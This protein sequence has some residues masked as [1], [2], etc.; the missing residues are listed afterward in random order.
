MQTG[1]Y[2]LLLESVDFQ[3]CGRVV[4]RVSDL[5]WDLSYEIWGEQRFPIMLFLDGALI[6]YDWEDFLTDFDFNAT[7]HMRGNTMRLADKRFA[8]SSFA[9]EDEFM[10]RIISTRG[11]A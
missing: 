7:Y 8:N 10:L 11:V 9:G 5:C 1:D 6:S 2:L 3:Y 4:H